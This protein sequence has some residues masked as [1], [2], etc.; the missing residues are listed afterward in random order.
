MR[1]SVRERD[2][3]TIITG[4][5]EKTRQL[6]REQF[7][8][9][10]YRDLASLSPD[11]IARLKT[12]LIPP[13]R[14]YVDG[15]IEEAQELASQPAQQVS[16]PADEGA[17][18]KANSPAAESEWKP[19][20]AFFVEFQEREIEGRAEERRIE[21]SHMPVKQ[22]AWQEEKRTEPILIEGER[23]YQW[24]QN[25][26]GSRMSEAPGPSE[27]EPSVET[28]PA[29]A[30]PVTINITQ[31][32]AFQPPKAETPVG[33]TTA[34]QPFPGALSSDEPF[35]LGVSF[36]L[37]GPGADETVKRQTTFCAQFHVLNLS[38]KVK[39][40]M[41]STEATPVSGDAP[42]EALLPDASLQ[43][44]VYRLRAL[45]TLESTPPSVGYLE[46]PTLRVV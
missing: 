42:Y 45:V 23:L 30:A 32:R 20:A 1:V 36:E 6:L 21:V 2:D 15:W 3:L 13:L 12:E 40:S 16:E 25:Q 17:G 8:V 27:E 4:I 44:G 9:E 18:G 43:P 7:D 31:I 28:Q 33:A 5:S 10:T 14:H 24:M 38:T 19:F 29:P 35:A 41:G 39:T 11:A 22:G 34:G 26:V 37:I 46:V